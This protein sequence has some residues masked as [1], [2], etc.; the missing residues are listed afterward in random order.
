MNSGLA[1]TFVLLMFCFHFSLNSAVPIN[2]IEELRRLHAHEDAIRDELRE[3][4]KQQDDL[5]T[6]LLGTGLLTL[7]SNRMR[8]A[9][10]N[11]K[12]NDLQ[13][14]EVDLNRE[15]DSVEKR[16]KELFKDVE[17]ALTEKT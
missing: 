1:R 11:Q 3:L 13:K 12:L 7:P 14:K 6:T 15:L 8:D 2:Y 16:T 5:K 4:T 17:T 9:E 10:Y